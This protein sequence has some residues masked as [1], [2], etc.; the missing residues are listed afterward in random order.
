MHSSAQIRSNMSKGQLLTCCIR[1][2]RV[3][4]AIASV[5]REDF[6]PAAFAD[7]AYVDAEIP[8]PAGRFL[9]EPL[10]FCRLLELAEIEPT[11]RVLDIGCGLGYSTAVISQ[12]AKKVVA[13]EENQELASEARQRL[14][15][16]GLENIE[17]ATSPLAS[18]IAAQRP[19]DV[20]VVGGAVQVIPAKLLE[21]LA[22]G[23]R[24]VAVESTGLRPGERSGL[25]TT[26]K[27]T[28]HGSKF[29]RVVGQ[30]ANVP[31][32]P[33]FEKHPTF[34]F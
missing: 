25:G 26:L 16:C 20:I 18:G 10:V 5:K 9:I 29:D 6:V 4:H 11:D 1:D 30:D 21:Q 17:V 32:L 7:S 13:L 15:T 31:L 12:L 8:L 27:I 22:D 33:G 14:A 34:E 28:R 24:L 2:E 23:G 3:L 19:F